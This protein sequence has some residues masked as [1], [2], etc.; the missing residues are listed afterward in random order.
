MINRTTLT[1]L[2]LA[3][4]VAANG[5]HAADK[6]KIGFIST[7]SGPSAALGV[8]I[9]D[10][11]LLAVKTNGGK[12][13]GLP[14]EVL[15]GDD[16]FKPDVGRQL[17][18]KYVKLDKVNF[19]TGMVFSNIMLAS[20]PVAFE[21]KV[22][23]V[24]PNAAPSPLAGA[25]CNPYFFVA[26]WP[27]DAYHEAAGQHATNKG[28]KSAYL[29]APNYQAGKD[30]LAG[31]KRFYKGQVVAEV[32]TQLGQLDYSAELAQ[33]RAAKPAALYI[34]LPG[35]MGINFIK[36]FVASGM[37][38][39]IPLIVPGFGSDQDIIRPVGDAMLGLFDTA[40]WAIDLD[41]PAN[42]KFVAAFEKEYKRLPSVF[43]AQGW[44]TA[45]LIDSAVRGVGGKVENVEA[46]RK[47]MK[48]AK[49]DS[50][51]GAF[52]FNRNQYPIQNY[53]LRVVAKDA[54]GRLINK[55]IGTIFKDHGDAYVQDCKMN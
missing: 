29:I 48:S 42:K 27:N 52:K 17:A 36:Q 34:F 26:S 9:R 45:M 28:Y 1:T 55:S 43:A 37:S 38:Q 33:V 41:N 11:F 35:G 30:S 4:A 13:G 44:D 31:F 16:Q 14:A 50:V 6:L 3:A 19:L 40:H 49:F 8:D 24:S 23:Y 54:K 47:A 12:L 5:A 10:A 15:I 46:V 21:S 22:I 53:Y 7:L 51:R 20:V 25:Q 2:F 39:D 18:D 32:Y